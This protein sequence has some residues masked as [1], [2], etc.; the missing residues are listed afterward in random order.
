MKDRLAI[1]IGG[2][3]IEICKFNEKCELISSKKL[4]TKKFSIG[5]VEFLDEIKNLIR[6][7]LDSSICKIGISFNCVIKRGVIVYSSL[8]GG[9]MDYDVEGEFLKEFNLPVKIMNDVNAM[10]LAESVFGRGSDV[11]SFVLLNLGTGV[12]PSFV[13]GGRTTEGY[14]GN[15]GEISQRELLIPEFDGLI[16]NDDLISGKGISN[17]YKKISKKEMD[18][19]EIFELCRKGDPEALGALTIFRKYLASFLQDLSYFYNPERI[20]LN[21]SL[22]KS[23]DLFLP[24]V[25][26]TYRENTLEIFHFK[27]MVISDIDH[28]ACLGVIQ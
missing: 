6:E 24:Q 26:N 3:K 18:A 12:R 13:V 20:I 15:F 16:K 4:N 19:L 8:L 14:M 2:S 21:G 10:A 11:E 23:S 17:L 1:D 7:N 28:G 22:K 9:R 5:G 25:V 27:D